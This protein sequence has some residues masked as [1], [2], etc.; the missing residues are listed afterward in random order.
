[1]NAVKPTSWGATESGAEASS[2]FFCQHLLGKNKPILLPV[3]AFL[4]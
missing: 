2:E 1:M 3:M 4:S